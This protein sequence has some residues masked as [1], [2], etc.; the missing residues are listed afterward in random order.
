MI[1]PKIADEGC[2]VDDTINNMR[3]RYP[4]PIMDG[5]LN[6]MCRFLLLALI[7]ATALIIW[8]GNVTAIEIKDFVVQLS[9]LAIL[10][11]AT[12]RII[13]LGRIRIRKDPL[14]A[15]VAFYGVIIFVGYILSNRSSINTRALVPQLYGL[16]IFLITVH[17]FE[18][19]HISIITALCT[20][21]G[22][23]AALYGIVQY[24]NIDPLHW[25]IPSYDVRGLMVSFFGQKNYFAL[26][27]VLM[28]PMAAA[29]AVMAKHF[30]RLA[31]GYASAAVMLAALALSRS[32]GGLIAF[33]LSAG[34]TAL[35]VFAKRFTTGKSKLHV[36]AL[37]LIVPMAAGAV[38]F[39]L[40]KSIQ[41]D[42]SGLVQM[43]GIRMEYYRTGM[44]IIGRHPIAG[45]GPGSFVIQYP[46]NKTHKTLTHDPNKVLSHVHNDFI[47]IWVE[48]GLLG[49]F[50]YLGII[51]LFL[52]RWAKHYK[53]ISSS[54]D[55]LV[56]LCSLASILGY[57]IY[58]PFTVAGR[59]MSSTFFF[60]LALGVGY[61]IMDD[62][63]QSKRWIDIPNPVAR[64]YWLIVP[65]SLGV[66]F[67]FATGMRAVIRSYQSDILLKRATIYSSKGRHDPALWYLNRAVALRPNSVE[68][69]YQRGY[70]FFQ[71]GFTDRA[72][73]DYKS[74][75]KLAPNYVNTAFNTASCYYRKRDWANAIR[76]AKQSHRLFPD[77]DAPLLMLANCYY[78]IR[79]PQKALDYCNLLLKLDKYPSN[80][81]AGNL[82][83]RLLKILNIKN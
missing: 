20:V 28:I 27:L 9:C 66:I 77:Y 71:K 37:L 8:H 82:K 26:Y 76:M 64:R 5:F 74:V 75:N 43:A 35:L 45:A 21:T 57:L 34:I 30:I 50:T 47:E 83:N 17:G 12:V 51:C 48:Y 33:F 55:R 2:M 4:E 59:Y 46:L 29:Y 14:L 32:R 3:I 52:F 58:S 53:S 24:L 56:L 31:A 72:L 62:E 22:T 60:W 36:A 15:L 6:I 73:G 10:C 11:I 78:Y 70:V 7:P 16:L 18:K 19:K 67:M 38:F 81:K 69:Y 44:E 61:L 25:M 49:L 63:N 80:R 65:M 41:K 1:S 79:Q 23:A 13:F 39:F 68:A 40:P 42:F 54:K